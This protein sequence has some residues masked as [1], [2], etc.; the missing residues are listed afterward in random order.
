MPDDDQLT[1]DDDCATPE[2]RLRQAV[3]QEIRRRLEAEGLAWEPIA[4][5]VPALRAAVGNDPG[6]AALRRAELAARA[7]LE[8]V[9]PGEADR[10]GLPALD[11][12]PREALVCDHGV[13]GA[14]WWGERGRRTLAAANPPTARE[15][16]RGALA[17][18]L[19]D[20]AMLS[21][22]AGNWPL[23]ALDANPAEV[24]AA[25]GEA[26]R[27][28]LARTGAEDAYRVIRRTRGPKPSR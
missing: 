15:A 13:P 1:T 3:A 14:W 9:R 22:L 23:V 8:A 25:E 6:T 12:P 7:A 19:T 20:V 16:R 17:P 21:L 28:V 24:I 5:A 27:K 2:A 18:T 26:I 4:A 11:L 10:L